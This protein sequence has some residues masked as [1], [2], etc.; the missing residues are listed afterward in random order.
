MDFLVGDALLPLLLGWPSNR[1]SLALRFWNQTCKHQSTELKLLKKISHTEFTCTSLA[2]ISHCFARASRTSIPGESLSSKALTK[3]SNCSGVV[4]LRFGFLFPVP[5]L[6]NEYEC[7][8]ALFLGGDMV[9]SISSFVM[10]L[11]FIDDPE[12]A[13]MG[14]PGAPNGKTFTGVSGSASPPPLAPNASSSS[15][16]SS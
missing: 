7:L 9:P 3:H 10:P 4:R 1:A 13:D 2:V 16:S 14:V 8:L 11:T 5:G 6:L 15:S 12:V